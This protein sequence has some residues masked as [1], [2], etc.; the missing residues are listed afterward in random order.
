[1]AFKSKGSFIC[2]ICCNMGPWFIFPRPKDR[3]PHPT[4]GFK[5]A[6]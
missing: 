4:A 5:P 3:S 2:H 6:T 1:V